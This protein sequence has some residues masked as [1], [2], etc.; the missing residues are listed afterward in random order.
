MKR[1]LLLRHAKASPGE[2]ETGDFQRPLTEW[3]QT[4]AGMVG[5]YMANRGLIPERAI[6]SAARRARETLDGLWQAWPERPQADWEETL[7][8]A[9]AA[10]LNQR[11][12]ILPETLASVLV[13]GHNP[14]IEELARD[15]AGGG[16][17]QAL[18]LMRTKYPTAALAV[19]D[20]DI[21][22][23]ADLRTGVADLTAFVRPQEAADEWGNQGPENGPA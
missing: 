5:Q 7:Y 6:C 15:L 13:V 10:T 21:D 3:G 14:G 9:T 12:T 19:L 1:I 8:G 2:S 22:S 16:E 23:W 17:P 11:L 18:A 20:A 4:A